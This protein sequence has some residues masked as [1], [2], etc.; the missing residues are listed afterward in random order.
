[1][2]KTNNDTSVSP[3]ERVSS[4][5]NSCFIIIMKADTS[6][7]NNFTWIQDLRQLKKLDRIKDGTATILPHS[8]I[9]QPSYKEYL[10]LPSSIS[11]LDKEYLAHP[12]ITNELLLS[13]G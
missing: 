11:S 4:L 5:I 8:T 10:N 1:M 9:I 6:V 13:I 2:L 3:Y 12:I 7:S